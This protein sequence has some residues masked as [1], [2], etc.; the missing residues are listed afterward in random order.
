MKILY[1][2]PSVASLSWMPEVVALFAT[3]CKPLAS[4]LAK[5]C[6]SWKDGFS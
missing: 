2:Y 5:G 3:R 4:S 6:L 1:F